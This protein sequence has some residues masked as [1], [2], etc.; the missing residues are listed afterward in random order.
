MAELL[1]GR[2]CKEKGCQEWWVMAVIQALGK[3]KQ[4]NFTS[5]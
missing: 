5:F 4:E 3:L 1:M 2:R